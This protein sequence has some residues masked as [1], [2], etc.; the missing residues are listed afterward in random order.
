MCVYTVYITTMWSHTIWQNLVPAAASYTHTNTPTTHTSHDTNIQTHKDTKQHTY[1][2]SNTDIIT[3]QNAL[4]LCQTIMSHDC[5]CAP[6]SQHSSGWLKLLLSVTPQETLW[7]LTSHQPTGPKTNT[8]TTFCQNK[9][10]GFLR[11]GEYKDIK[12]NLHTF[13]FG[14][15]SSLLQI[16]SSIYYI[17]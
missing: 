16:V 8:V 7:H 12:F 15:H 11:A 1:K 13:S 5:I 14:V 2:P 6:N 17:K 9:C 4:S 10:H 3:P